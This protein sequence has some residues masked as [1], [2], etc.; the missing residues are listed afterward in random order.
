MRL[1]PPALGI[2]IASADQLTKYWALATL[3]G[4]GVVEVTPFFNLVLV[5]NTGVSFGLLQ[6]FGEAGR[7]GLVML[8]C[9]VG[10]GLAVWL[11][12]ESRLLPQCA[13]CL[14]LAGAVGNVID[15]MRFGAVVD[16]LDFHLM[17]Y[18]WPAFNIAD[19]AIVIGAILLMVDGLFFTPSAPDEKRT[20]V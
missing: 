5:W 17:G 20:E 1:L 11:F 12:R 19:S 3:S 16:F 18:H 4:A 7:W 13:L 2:A 15:R 10:I 14:V 9:A 8:A 6:G